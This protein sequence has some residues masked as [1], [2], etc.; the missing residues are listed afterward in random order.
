MRRL[1]STSALRLLIALEGIDPQI[2]RRVV[3]NRNTTLHELHRIIQIAFGWLDYHLYE[4]EVGGRRFE[5]PHEEAEGDDSTKATLS[6]LVDGKGAVFAYTYDF[7]DSWRHSI[8]VE[9]VVPRASPGWLPFLEDGA[10]RGPP[11]DSGGIGGYEELLR[12]SATPES[13][14][15]EDGR[16][17]LEWA[18]PDFDP[19]EFS[20]TQARHAMLLCSGW[21]ILRR[22]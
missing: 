22:R 16:S 11:E 17:L 6:K 15:D 21:G 8:E 2:W 5:E 7:G 3:V 19:E 12:A 14:L 4:F 20:V 9:G 1:P 10:R 18:G 13:M